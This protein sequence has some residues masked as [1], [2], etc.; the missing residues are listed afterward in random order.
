MVRLSI[1]LVGSLR[2]PQSNRRRSR[3]RIPRAMPLALCASL[4][5]SREDGQRSFEGRGVGA[6]RMLDPDAGPARRGQRQRAADRHSPA[7]S[8]IIEERDTDRAW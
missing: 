2:P 4:H 7:R 5:P 8:I 1:L 6:S 3:S